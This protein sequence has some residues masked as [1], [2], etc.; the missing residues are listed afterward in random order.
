MTVTTAVNA[1]SHPQSP[2]NR[3]L[4]H[5]LLVE[6]FGHEIYR[7][8]RQAAERR[9]GA[10]PVIPPCD[11]GLAQ[12]MRRLDFILVGERSRRIG[13]ERQGALAFV[14]GLTGERRT[15]S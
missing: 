6:Q 4:W 12:G 5:R 13:S 8:L 2:A 11:P 9:R 15:I 7:L 14:R 1:D 10:A 3:C